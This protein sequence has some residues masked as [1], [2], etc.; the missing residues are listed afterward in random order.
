MAQPPSATLAADAGP[1]SEPEA[2]ASPTAAQARDPVI[3]F[4]MYSAPTTR[5]AE[6]AAAGFTLA[7]PFYPRE[8]E[9]DPQRLPTARE[10]GLSTLIPVGPH[11]T[12]KSGDLLRASP[13][14]LRDQVAR[15]VEAYAADDTVAGWYLLPEELDGD[16]ATDVAYVELARATIRELDPKSRP[17]LGYQPNVRSV[18]RLQPV[19]RHL[20]WVAKGAYVNY[21]R[22]RD[23]RAWVRSSVGDLLAATEPA[24]VPLAA[25]EM[26][27]DPPDASPRD[28]ADWVRHDV[29]LALLSG[30][31]GVLVFSG[32]R[33]PNFDRYDDY[34]AAYT[35]IVAELRGRGI[36]RAAVHGERVE[37]TASQG[38]PDI[39]V[40][41]HGATARH[42]TLSA[43]RADGVTI[44][45]NSAPRTIACTLDGPPAEL[46]AGRATWIGATRRL[47]LPPVGGAI[48]R[49]SG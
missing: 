18:D 3:P 38:P 22:H 29:L 41:L 35:R 15:R 34:F 31:R 10:H 27:Q 36:A 30:A 28:I 8:L 48:L 7:G 39:E 37:I 12:A 13:R 9:L 44:V 46:I 43:R 47:L 17:I 45:V 11:R 33:R 14:A 49:R 2:A 32:W 23:Q 1:D 4:G 40:A 16:V 20:D 19:A 6:L 5:L 24:Q 42:P 21:T 26:F 25:V